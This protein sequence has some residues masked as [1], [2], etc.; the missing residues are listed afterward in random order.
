MPA[1]TP[2][3]PT[4]PA[5]SPAEQSTATVAEPKTDEQPRFSAFTRK[6]F[7]QVKDPLEGQFERFLEDATVEEQRLMI[8]ILS[9]RESR[10]CGGRPRSPGEYEIGLYSAIESQISDCVCVVLPHDDMAPQ[11]EDFIAAPER[12]RKPRKAAEY[13]PYKPET[14]EEIVKR[15]SARFRAEVELFARDAGRPSLGLMIDI[16]ARWNQIH[17]DPETEHPR[18]CSRDGT[19]HAAGKRSGREGSIRSCCRR[20]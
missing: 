10:T 3:K 16:L 19:G 7:A 12:R 1:K 14:N 8:E 2:T 6:I 11:V 13:V 20:A 5:Q 4:S 17:A 18:G 15:F 9:D